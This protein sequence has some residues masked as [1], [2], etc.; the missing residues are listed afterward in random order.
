[1]ALS[2]PDR[3]QNGQGEQR[4]QL[5]NI[6][7]TY[8]VT[9][10][11]AG[12]DF[13]AFA[14]EIIGLVGPNGAGKS[15]LMRVLTGVTTANG[16][17]ITVNGRDIPLGFYNRKVARENGIACAYQELSL[18]S[19]LSV[20]EN[21]GVT[22][23]DHRVFGEWRWRKKTIEFAREALEL[24]FPGNGINVTRSVSSLPLAQ[25][26]IIE[27]ARAT[28]AQGL[29]VLILDEP[30][31]SLTSDFILQLHSA[32]KQLS[33]DGVTI[34]YI[35]HKL[36]E[37]EHISNRIVIMKNGVNVWE[38]SITG[39]STDELVARLGGKVVRVDRE[40]LRDYSAESYVNVRGLTTKV[41]R[42]VSL[43]AQK[44]E[45]VGVAGLAGSGQKELL[46]ELFRVGTGHTNG[47]VEVKG[48]VA[49]VSGD[50][51][52]EGIFRLWDIA[53]NILASSIRQVLRWGL[54]SRKKSDA[55]AQEWYTK[56]K[57]KAEGMHRPILELSGGNQQKAI[58]ARGMAPA[59]DIILL[60]DPTR[61]VDVET[62]KDIYRLLYE[63]KESGK[64]VIW[65]ST[66]DLEMEEC[67]RVY[68]MRGGEIVRELKGDEITLEN[69]VGTSFTERRVADVSEGCNR[70]SGRTAFSRSMRGILASRSTIPALVFLCVVLANAVLNINSISYNGISYLME[71]AVPLV[72][73]SVAQMFIVSAGDIDLS[74]GSAIGLVSVLTATVA[75]HNTW[76]GLLC[77]VAF[78]L[79]YSL[80]GALVHVRKLPAIVVSLGAMFV[81]LGI[82]LIIQATPGGA[83]PGWLSAVFSFEAPVIPLAVYFCLFAAGV[84][85]WILKRSKYGIILRGIGNNPKA[86]IRGGWS[87]LVAHVTTYAI[88]AAFII[89]AGICITGF[90]MGSDANATSSYMMMSIAAIILGGC[91]FSGGI[92]EPVGVVVGA[93]TISLISSVLAFL[94]IAS[95]FQTAFVGCILLAA[96]AVRRLSRRAG[97]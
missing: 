51:Q 38:T 50:R 37:I 91:E 90:S 77:Y 76:L 43:K 42:D 21:F 5:T 22:H 84:S 9:K 44:G 26:Q 95:Q 83:S 19:N 7:K 59:S 20:Y 67:D 87:Y 75:V 82:A 33:A 48:R 55:L 40:D 58:I 69:V 62:K 88:A 11:I 10:A 39:T 41:L 47:S 1:M 56:L 24:V 54:I 14:G 8:G 49:Y 46:G 16:G 89:L 66:E 31:S 61:G 36:E 78:I 2:R 65:S 72:L 96:L 68:V 97:S 52:N 64:C 3:K 18:C 57:F 45:I 70:D 80:V 30:T 73:A 15:T 23:A 71:A 27:I 34:I 60:D 92:A 25:Q 35:S 6:Q 79:A 81:W 4:L 32:I 53:G 12:V 28:T 17:T 63:A 93:L 86:I 94:Y 13:S 85:S 74:I 29:R